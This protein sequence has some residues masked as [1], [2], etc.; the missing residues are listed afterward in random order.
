MAGWIFAARR[1]GNAEARMPMLAP[2]RGPSRIHSHTMWA[3]QPEIVEIR[4]ITQTARALPP[5]PPKRPTSAP[6]P[7]KTSA[8]VRFDAPRALRTPISVVRA[9]TDTIME[10]AMRNVVSRR[11]KRPP[12]VAWL[13]M[14]VAT[15]FRVFS[16]EMTC[17]AVKRSGAFGMIA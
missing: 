2:S 12:K 15:E 7:R 13:A 9:V 14:C 5:R 4:R 8:T 17:V 6:S 1:A 10:L 16:V 3:D 11:R